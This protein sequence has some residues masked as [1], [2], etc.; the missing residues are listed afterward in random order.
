MSVFKG[1]AVAIVTPFKEEDLSV[2]YDAFADLIDFQI[3]HGTDAIVV[4]GSTGEAATMTEQEHLDVCKFCIDY[5]KK[6]VPVIAGSGSNCTQT[7]INLSKEIA[8]YGADG[9]LV[10]HPYYN[11]ATQ[12]GLV[13][14]FTAVA[15]A[16]DGCPIVLYNVPSRTGGNINPETVAQLVKDVPNIVGIKEASGNISQIVKL[17][18]LTDG[19]I[20]LYSGNDDQVVPLMSMGGIGVISVVANIAPQAV[21]DMCDRFLKGDVAGAARLQKD[22]LALCENL[23]SEVNP[24]PV[25]KACNLMGMNVGPLRMPL[26]E[27]EEANAKKLEDAMRAFGLL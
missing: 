1:S 24:I 4:C 18:T 20:E 27:M 7:A 8:G 13:K 16:A 10:I 3:D 25:K 2:N 12:K 19:N 22:T 17:M 11:K 15:E 5:T 14:H 9:L 23:F 21:H 26:T 6:R